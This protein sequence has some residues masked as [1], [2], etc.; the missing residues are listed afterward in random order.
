MTSKYFTSKDC[1]KVSQHGVKYPLQ[2]EHK[3][4]INRTSIDTSSRTTKDRKLLPF[5]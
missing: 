2:N 5:F 1:V 4:V 3:H